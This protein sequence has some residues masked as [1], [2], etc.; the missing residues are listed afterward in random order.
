[1]GLWLGLGCVA[2]A[3]VAVAWA[4]WLRLWL[5]LVTCVPLLRLTM[6]G[7]CPSQCEVKVVSERWWVEGGE[8][9]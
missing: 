9:E 2:V 8:R 5:R 6:T 3:A 7:V 4:V 1:M